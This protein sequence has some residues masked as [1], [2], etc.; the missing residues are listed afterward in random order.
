MKTLLM[1]LLLASCLTFAQKQE[2]IK[3][4]DLFGYVRSYVKSDFTKNS[5][6]FLLY[7]ARIGLKGN[8][9]S[10]ISYRVFGDLAQLGNV[11]LTKD[12]DGDVTNVDASNLHVLLDAYIKVK[13]T[14]SV[15]FTFG[16][17]KLPFSTS[18]LESP[19]AMEFVNR[20]Y[21]KSTSP[22]LRDIGGMVEF[23]DKKVAPL[24][25][26]ASLTNGSGENTSETDKTANY[27]FRA[28]YD[29]LSNFSV[30]ANYYGG[31]L[32]GNDVN[33]FNAGSNVRFGNLFIAGE[34]ALRN[35]DKAGTKTDGNS[36]FV[37][38]SYK[39][40]VSFY[41]F[42]SI[43]PAFRYEMYDPNT[44]V[45]NDDMSRLTAGLT[46]ELIENSNTLVRL[47]YESIQKK[48]GSDSNLL[49]ILFQVS[50]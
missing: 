7:N 25:L 21:T 34:Y 20:P 14:G 50:F 9:N 11:S 24:T 4:P 17:F 37:F 29:I 38:S 36:F 8:L 12:I 39:V 3:T 18:N 33:I 35:T 43:T 16:Q 49:Y 31:K 27:T 30:S 10:S 28:V 46:F 47:N 41:L 23:S 13:L 1:L 2:E 44:S 22:G 48:A 40:P 6:E 19:A 32:S 26:A 45:D 15:A 5:N 42:S